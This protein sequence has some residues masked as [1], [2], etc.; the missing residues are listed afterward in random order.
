MMIEGSSEREELEMRR[1]QL[2]TRSQLGEGHLPC[3]T[4]PIG[5]V[6]EYAARLIVD[7][8][9]RTGTRLEPDLE[10]AR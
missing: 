3:R 9:L 7:D 10:Q 8:P 1:A 4:G 6:V 2:G 5:I